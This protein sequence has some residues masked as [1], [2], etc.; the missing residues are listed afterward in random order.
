M[1]ES[2]PELMPHFELLVILHRDT[3]LA[4]VYILI[5][6]FRFE[7]SFVTVCQLLG[8]PLGSFHHVGGTLIQC[9]ER[10]RNAPT[11]K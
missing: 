11:E 3:F 2:H 7:I 8:Q 1:M 6:R 5:S 4:E 10:L 9:N